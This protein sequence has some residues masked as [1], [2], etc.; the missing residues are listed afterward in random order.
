ML[1]ERIASHSEVIRAIVSGHSP[2][3]WA[4][5]L[6]GGLQ[7]GRDPVI[8]SVRQDLNPLCGVTTIRRSVSHGLQL[9]SLWRIPTAAVS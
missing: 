8:V 9:Q 2:C 5:H 4:P 3:C 7:L 1:G 6:R